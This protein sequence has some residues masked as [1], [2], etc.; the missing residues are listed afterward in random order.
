VGLIAV[1]ALM[2]ATS[3]ETPATTAS[4]P[5]VAPAPPS[6][7]TEMAVATEAA[8]P[9]HAG[10]T[11][12]TEAVESKREAVVAY[13]KGDY[14]TALAQLE[15]AVASAPNDPEAAPPS[16]CRSSTKPSVSMVN[17]GPIGSTAH[18]PTDC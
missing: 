15:A 6:T 17:A 9:A 2:V 3:S 1:I 12:S 18:V 11:V 16:R 7:V 13:A 8:T 4:A 14:G 10:H 5:E